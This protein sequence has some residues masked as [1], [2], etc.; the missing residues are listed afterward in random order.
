[1][2]T[3][4]NHRDIPFLLSIQCGLCFAFVFWTK[5]Q[6]SLPVDKTFL[7]IGLILSI[8]TTLL[9]LYGYYRRKFILFTPFLVYHVITLIVVVSAASLLSAQLV[10]K[11]LWPK[12]D[13]AQ[14][15]LQSRDDNNHYYHVL[16]S[17]AQIM[18]VVFAMTVAAGDNVWKTFKFAMRLRLT[19]SI[20]ER[21][22]N[23]ARSGTMGNA[24]TT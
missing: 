14:D 20:D 17:L 7:E 3:D 9:A 12:N 1:M 15:D 4:K 24:C 8:Q 10:H 21:L 23:G 22:K 16:Q 19:G 5:E 11:L 18:V 13:T 6:A 2:S